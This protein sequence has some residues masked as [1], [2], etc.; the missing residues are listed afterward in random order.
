MGSSGIATAYSATVYSP[1]VAEGDFGARLRALREARGLTQRQ[2]ADRTGLDAGHIGMLET[3]KYEPR[4]E[5]KRKLAQGLGVPPQDLDEPR[6]KRSW[7]ADF[8][9]DPRYSEE[10][11]RVILQLAEAEEQRR[12]NNRRK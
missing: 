2:L 8:A 4:A 10:V 9:N 11:K 7:K 6:G 5:T 3:N 1:D 12:K